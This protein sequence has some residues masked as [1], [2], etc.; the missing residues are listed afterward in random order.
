VSEGRTSRRS[1]ASREGKRRAAWVWYTHCPGA[2]AG[3]DPRRPRRLMLRQ[4]STP[5]RTSLPLWYR[6][7]LSGRR[8][9]TV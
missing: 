8:I 1:G 2:M 4:K 6:M 3:Q 7:L 5:M 9:S